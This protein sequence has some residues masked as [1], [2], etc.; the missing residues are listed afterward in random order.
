V[1]FVG[2]FRIEGAGGSIVRAGSP[3]KAWPRPRSRRLTGSS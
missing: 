2:A 3:S 1:G